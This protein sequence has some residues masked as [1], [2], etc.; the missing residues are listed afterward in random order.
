MD[1][2]GAHLAVVLAVLLALPACGAPVG[3]ARPSG[4]PTAAP[5]ADPHTADL[6]EGNAMVLETTEAGP[7]LCLGV[8]RTSLP[9]Q[10]GDVAITNWDWSAVDGEETSGDVIWSEERFHVVGTFDGT[11]FT[12]TQPPGPADP[13]LDSDPYAGDEEPA[14]PEPT[15]GWTG[16]DPQRGGQERAG[17]GLAT[18]KEEPTYAGGWLY[19]PEE[20]RTEED[21]LRFQPV[22]TVAFTDDPA[23][24]EAQIR[25][26]WGGPLCLT[27]FEKTERE[28]HRIQREVFD[29]AEELGLR[30]MSGGA[31]IRNNRVTFDALT[32]SA[33]QIAIL[34]ER[35]GAD[36]IYI[37]AALRPVD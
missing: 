12:L 6:Y 28:L 26:A 33:E 10:C 16:P 2:Q 4:G 24:Y 27:R 36:T 18:V 19:W 23:R 34:E 7:M 9:P 29:D 5:A 22:L 31:D 8:V 11:S 37:S 15:G 3:E 30:I 17:A 21:A 20:P 35:Y 14:C 25:G 32:V 13:R 1:R